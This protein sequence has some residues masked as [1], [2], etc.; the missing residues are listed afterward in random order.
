MKNLTTESKCRPFDGRGR[1]RLLALK[2][3]QEGYNQSDVARRIK[4]GSQL[5]SRW[6]RTFSARGEKAL[7]AAGRVGRKPLLDEQQR[8]RLIA[9]LL[10]GPERLGSETPLWTCSRVA[11]LIQGRV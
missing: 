10:E 1:R 5:V 11:H 6:A 9:R 3:L 8:E 2:L 4:V 7:S